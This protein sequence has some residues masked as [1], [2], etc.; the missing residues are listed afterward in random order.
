MQDRFD[1]TVLGPH[2]QARL[3]RTS[4]AGPAALRPG[5]RRATRCSRLAERLKVGRA[6]LAMR[7]ARPEASPALD[8]IALGDWLAARW[9][10]EHARR[11][12]WDLFTVS[13]LN[14]AGDQASTALAATV[15]K[16]ALL[17]GRGAADI[18][19]AAVPLG[20]LHG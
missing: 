20:E 17:G 9:Q 5:A 2:G 13:S 15:I 10:G 19:I 18:G 4:A 7:F 3:R 11:V 14:V 1:V 6:A 12:L 8:Q 16:T